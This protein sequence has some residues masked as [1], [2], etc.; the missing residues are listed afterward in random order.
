MSDPQLTEPEILEAIEKIY[1]AG[2]NELETMYMPPWLRNDK[3]RN[4]FGQRYGYEFRYVGHFNE[5]PQY[6][7]VGKSIFY[8][9]RD[10]NEFDQEIRRRG[11]DE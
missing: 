6:D 11:T 10:I 8:L 3:L 5:Q 1:E 9:M 4:E 2:S 7:I